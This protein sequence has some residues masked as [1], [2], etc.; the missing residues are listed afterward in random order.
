VFTLW[1]DHGVRP[2]DA[3]YAYALLPGV[4]AQQLAEWVA[5]PPVRVISNT[6]EQQAVINDQIGV[7]EIVFYTPGSVVLG[8]GLVAKVDHPCLA[9]LVKHGDSTRIAVSSPGGEFFTVQLT[10]TTPQ[11]ERRVAFELPD[12]DK[13]GK[14]KV[15]EIPVGW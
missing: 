12:G 4:N 6:T 7:G 13:A 9:L 5:H 10:I 11:G 15:L 3:Q 8:G 14:S 1:V 2:K